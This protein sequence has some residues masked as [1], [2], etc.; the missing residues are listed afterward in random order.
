MNGQSYATQPRRRFAGDAD[1]RRRRTIPEQPYGY[2]NRPQMMNN[3]GGTMPQQT[4]YGYSG[5]NA[6]PA[7]KPVNVAMYAAGGAAA[8]LV[9]GAGA[10]YAYN[11]MYG[12][13][14]E[15]HRR[16]RVGDFRS[17]SFCVVTAPGD[18]NGAF[19]ACEQCYRIYGFSQ[20][21]SAD[22]CQTSGGCRYTTPQSF[23]RD[24]LA[25]TGFIPKAYT[26]PLR[27]SFTSITGP[28]IDTESI[29]PPTTKEEVELAERFNRTMSFKPELFL[30]S[31]HQLTAFPQPSAEE[32]AQKHSFMTSILYASVV[33]CSDSGNLRRTYCSHHRLQQTTVAAGHA[34]KLETPN[35][36]L[37]EGLER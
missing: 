34:A 5:Y 2:A 35:S 23:N 10:M 14:W 1:L 32:K 16:R 21:P 20:C 30:V 13:S 15:I 33:M 36:Q 9:V 7:Q 18:R 3:Y 8:G 17:Q 37:P 19:M 11:N 26:P 6:V 24:E 31:W 25:E 12:D 4:P 29:C 27:V 22:S 28:G